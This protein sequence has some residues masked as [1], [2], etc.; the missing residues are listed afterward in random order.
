MFVQVDCK[1]NGQHPKPLHLG[2][3]DITKMSKRLKCYDS[4][5]AS[6]KIPSVDRANY[7]LSGGRL[8]CRWEFAPPQL[9]SLRI[10]SDILQP[11]PKVSY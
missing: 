10:S 4:R 5:A 3:N 2:T 8:T 9:D 11:T 1:Q 7:A 6:W